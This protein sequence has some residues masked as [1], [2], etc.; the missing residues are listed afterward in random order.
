MNYFTRTGRRQY[1]TRIVVAAI[2]LIAA[3]TLTGCSAGM[4]NTESGAGGNPSEPSSQINLPEG[5]APVTEGDLDKLLLT[6]VDMEGIGVDAREISDPFQGEEILSALASMVEGMDISPV[7][8]GEGLNIEMLGDGT[9]RQRLMNIDADNYADDGL[10]AANVAQLG[11]SNLK[12]LRETTS[13]CKS[14]ALNP[15]ENSL[16]VRFSHISI[17]GI[18]DDPARIFAYSSQLSNSEGVV[19]TTYDAVVNY[20]SASLAYRLSGGPIGNR[21]TFEKLVRNGLKKVVSL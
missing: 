15:G 1:S 2:A 7:E 5:L 13:R 17:P 11:E 16:T 8:C 18:P 19:Q 20:R 14:I 9:Y 10:F 3:V 6:P 21:E 12:E 4:D